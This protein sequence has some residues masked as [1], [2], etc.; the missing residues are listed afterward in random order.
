MS[1]G[2]VDMQLPEAHRKRGE[3]EAEVS[4]VHFVQTNV[5]KGVRPLRGIRL[6]TVGGPSKLW[7]QRIVD[8][9]EAR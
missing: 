7:A 6:S 1:I 8:W 5:R 2:P 9:Y 4:L 3:A